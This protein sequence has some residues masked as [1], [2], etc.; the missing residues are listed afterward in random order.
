MPNFFSQAAKFKAE[1]CPRWFPIAVTSVSAAASGLTPVNGPSSDRR[2]I[3]KRNAENTFTIH[4]PDN[5]SAD[6]PTHSSWRFKWRRRRD[7]SRGNGTLFMDG[8]PHPCPGG[9][10]P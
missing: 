9:L 1:A 6:R 3:K 8:R 4:G 10:L 7:N 2:K 5:G